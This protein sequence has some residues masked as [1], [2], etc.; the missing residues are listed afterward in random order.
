[1]GSRIRPVGT[2]AIGLAR[3]E[4]LVVHSGSRIRRGMRSRLLRERRSWHRPREERGADTRAVGRVGATTAGRN[5]SAA[6][7]QAAL[8][9]RASRAGRLAVPWVGNQH[10]QQVAFADGSSAA[11][12][13]KRCQEGA[14]RLGEAKPK[15]VGLV[16]LGLSPVAG[17][18]RVSWE[19]VG[20]VGLCGL[21]CGDQFEQAA[22]RD[23]FHP[24]GTPVG[25]LGRK[26]HPRSAGVTSRR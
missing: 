1:M 4:D 8:C 3:A 19:G 18:G 20:E 22:E 26:R 16:Q 21:E 15:G 11:A 2:N 5:E 12:A 9:I 14:R 17:S 25:P 10:C 13:G 7:P 6:F 23:A 24:R